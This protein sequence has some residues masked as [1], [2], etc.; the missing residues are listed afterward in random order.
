[1]QEDSWP[2]LHATPVKSPYEG[3]LSSCPHCGT[4]THKLH[5]TFDAATSQ[6]TRA[7]E[8]IGLEDE[9]LLRLLHPYRELRVEVPVRMDDGHLEVFTGYR[10]QHNGAPRSVQR[11]HSLSPG[12]QSGRDTHTR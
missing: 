4:S 1:M 2:R 8:H 6:L 12:R 3:E 5:S 7:A 10:V 9:I 11:R